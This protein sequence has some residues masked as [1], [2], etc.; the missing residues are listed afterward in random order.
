MQLFWGLK[1]VISDVINIYIGQL[2]VLPSLCY[3]TSSS[4]K[5][6]EIQVEKMIK[7]KKKND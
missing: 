7:V 3:L 4:S 1:Q 5:V 2:K 6:Y